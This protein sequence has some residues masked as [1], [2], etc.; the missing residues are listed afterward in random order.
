MAMELTEVLTERSHLNKDLLIALA[1][2][3][4]RNEKVQ[5]KFRMAVLIRLAKIETMLSM[6]VV[7]ELARSQGR[8]E[9]Y[10]DKLTEDAKDAED[11]ISKHSNE[12][13]LAM[14][15]YIYGESEAPSAQGKTRRKWSGWE[16]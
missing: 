11:Y 1:T 10:A 6:I 15:N 8:Q 13:G 3:V 4:G 14:V 9:Y 16:I 2:A 7:G 5:Q 12:L